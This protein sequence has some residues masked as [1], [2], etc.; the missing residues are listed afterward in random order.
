MLG[1]SMRSYQ[2]PTNN[3]TNVMRQNAPIP[4]LTPGQRVDPMQP[5]AIP[6]GYSLG[7]PRDMANGGTMTY[8]PRYSY[9]LPTQQVNTKLNGLLNNN[10]GGAKGNAYDNM[11]TPGSVK[12]AASA[13]PVSGQ[14]GVSNVQTSITPQSIYPA[15]MTKAAVNQVQAQ[16][17]QASNLPYLMKMFD[18]PGASRSEANMGAA[19]PYVAQAQSQA[20]AGRAQIP[21]D[22][23]MANQRN[24]FMGQVARENEAL[25]LGNLSARMAEAQQSNRMNDI[26]R[27]MS[28]LQQLV[29]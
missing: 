5:G 29:G 14:P 9:K 13:F 11:G 23:F 3:T 15:W 20:L 18:R 7:V 24:L 12:P 22:D 10:Y 26:Q 27:Q 25:Q 8:D 19:L 1:N 17:D 16:A 28:L 21:F 6:Q 4:G 2:S